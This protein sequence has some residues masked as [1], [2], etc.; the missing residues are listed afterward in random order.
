MAF[1]VF[2]LVRQVNRLAPKPAPAAAPAIASHPYCLS[3]VPLKA[4]KCAQCTSELRAAVALVRDS[5]QARPRILL[6][7]IESKSKK[8]SSPKADQVWMYLVFLIILRRVVRLFCLVMIDM[9]FQAGD[10]SANAITV[11]RLTLH[12]AR[13]E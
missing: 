5:F 3:T 10:A 2:L 9:F 8:D 4:T 7:L 13:E 6:L 11:F 1:A 12:R